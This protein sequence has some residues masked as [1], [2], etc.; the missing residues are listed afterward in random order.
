MADPPQ[1]SRDI[2]I[3]SSESLSRQGFCNFGF[4]FSVWRRSEYKLRYVDNHCTNKTYIVG[5][6]SAYNAHAVSKRPNT[7]FLLERL[8]RSGYFCCLRQKANTSKYE[9]NRR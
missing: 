1:E 3:V 4:G 6:S 9:S 5:R 2:V 8:F 7:K